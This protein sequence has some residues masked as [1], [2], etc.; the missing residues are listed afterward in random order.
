MEKKRRTGAK[1]PGLQKQYNSRIKQEYMD[2]DYISDLSEKEKDW[3]NDFNEEFYGANL[4]FKNLDNNR[5]HKTIAEKKDCTDRN[6]A[7][8]RCMYGMA[9]ASGKVNKVDVI[10]TDQKDQINRT[11][12]KENSSSNI[13][14]ALIEYIDSKKST[15]ENE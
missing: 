2:Q 11:L 4:D 1:Y 3:L 10:I 5:F 8:N 9:K 13:E 15:S 7:R 14:D 6:N 12:N